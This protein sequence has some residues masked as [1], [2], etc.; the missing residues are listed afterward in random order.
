MGGN[1]MLDA[2]TAQRFC[3]PPLDSRRLSL[4]QLLDAGGIGWLGEMFVEPRI[5]CRLDGIR[6][7]D[8]SRG[9]SVYR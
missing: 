7:T 4:Q 3:C 2:R 9:R 5:K 8:R 1:E 6:S